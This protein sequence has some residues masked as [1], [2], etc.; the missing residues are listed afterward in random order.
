MRRPLS[1]QALPNFLGRGKG[2]FGH[3]GL[4]IVLPG[5]SRLGSSKNNF[6]FEKWHGQERGVPG[7]SCLWGV[8]LQKSSEGTRQSQL[9][10]SSRLPLHLAGCQGASIWLV[11]N[12]LFFK[13]LLFV[14]FFFSFFLSFLSLMDSTRLHT[15]ARFVS[16][17]GIEMVSGGIITPTAN[18]VLKP[19]FSKD[20]NNNKT[21]FLFLFM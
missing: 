4:R 3:S 13:A 11:V 9:P 1:S 15:L 12:D 18:T 2:A 21:R 8:S 17:I 7:S 14:L 20:N 5:L 19:H 6:K 16:Y 10:D